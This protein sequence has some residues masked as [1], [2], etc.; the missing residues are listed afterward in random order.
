[1][2]DLYWT[3]V[4]R[5]WVGVPHAIAALV[6]AAGAAAVLLVPGAGPHSLAPEQRV[7]APT[8]GPAPEVAIREERADAPFAVAGV[9]FGV[10]VDPG[11]AW[12]RLAARHDL[13]S[14]RRPLVV[15]VAV[16]NVS[17]LGFDPTLVS[18]L[19]RGRNGS[20]QAPS[21][22]GIVGPASLG[23]TGTLRPAAT[24]QQRLVFSVPAGLRRPVLAIQPA[25]GRA[26]E[27]R[28]PLSGG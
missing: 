14:G 27:V 11:A 5:D 9:R 20:L 22:S 17:R 10:D 25:P 19:L 7:A 13:G 21:R 2:A 6:L 23:R 24:A 16:E 1:M 4:D 8:A 15:A 12:A 26:L 28:V 3:V 18:Y